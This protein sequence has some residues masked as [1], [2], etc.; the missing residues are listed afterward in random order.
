VT[1]NPGQS[2]T[3]QVTFDPDHGRS[4]D[5]IDPDHQQRTTNPT[6]TISL[7]GT[8]DSTTGG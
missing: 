6:V 4:A 8:G 2:A 5:R 7:S 3:L 1:L